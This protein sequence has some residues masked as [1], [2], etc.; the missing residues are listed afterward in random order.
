VAAVLLLTLRGVPTIL[1]GDELGM[2]DQ[3]VPVSRG[4]D[5]FAANGGV[6]HDPTRT[7]MPWNE[8]PNGGFST[9]D[10]DVLWLPVCV[11]YPTINV[12]AQLRDPDSSLDLYRRLIALRRDS[13]ALRLGDYR[14]HP[15]SGAECLVYERLAPGERKVVALNLTDEPRELELAERG[16][17]AVSTNAAR[18]GSA[19]DGDTLRLGADE[20][21]V[22][23]VAP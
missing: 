23:E 13:D 12:E 6:S 16:R 22:I 17:I 19:V 7:P 1:Y 5:S 11:E 15:A 3:E 20:G 4:R 14:E 10:P 18:D 21:A 9:A 2:V 8:G